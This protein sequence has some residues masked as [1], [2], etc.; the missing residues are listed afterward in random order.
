M[1]G[2]VAGCAV[3]G[4]EELQVLGGLGRVGWVALWR[5]AVAVGLGHDELLSL[6][7]LKGGDDQAA[8]GA[9]SNVGRGPCAGSWVQDTIGWMRC[10]WDVGVSR[11][12][13]I[14]WESWRRII[15]VSVMFDVRFLV[16]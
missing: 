3:G 1:A 14:D 9:G 6:V 8:D 16:R 7:I 2:H 11:S 12:L 5:R 13:E 15:S 10:S 4:W